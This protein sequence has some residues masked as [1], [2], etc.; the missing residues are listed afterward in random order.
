MV[1]KIHAVRK[2]HHRDCGDKNASP[3]QHA[4]NIATMTTWLSVA[5][6][7]ALAAFFSSKSLPAIIAR[8]EKFEPLDI[9]LDA[10]FSEP[11]SEVSREL[12]AS[13]APPLRPLPVLRSLAR[14]PA[15]PNLQVTAP[16]PKIPDLP[17]VANSV[18]SEW[19]PATSATGSARS[20]DANSRSSLQKRLA[21]GVM[22]EPTYPPYSRRNHQEG[23]VIVEFAVD[24][25]GRVSAVFV[26]T[27][28]RWPLLN[29]A[30]VLTVYGWHFPPGDYVTLESPIVFR[31]Q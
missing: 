25:S 16:L 4:A 6:F 2:S 14:P 7:S 30:A 29:Q 3:L 28:C 13:T 15:M 19:Q 31:I 1:P 22:P 26:K 8:T 9:T 23:T 5:I 21:G 11:V 18:P 10:A 17:R 12:P 24:A 20:G 27:P